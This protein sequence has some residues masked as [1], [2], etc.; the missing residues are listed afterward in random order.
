M[1]VAATLHPHPSHQL[2]VASMA[3]RA[4]YNSFNSKL[5]QFKNSFHFS[6]LWTRTKK[7]SGYPKQPLVISPKY[8][9]KFQNTKYVQ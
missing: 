8:Q 2:S 4:L 7:A 5:K 1:T 3:D 9:L 6:L